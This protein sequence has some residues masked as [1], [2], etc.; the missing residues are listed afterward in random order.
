Y[1]A[2]YIYGYIDLEITII[3]DALNFP[4]GSCIFG[5]G[6]ILGSGIMMIHLFIRY[7]QLLSRPANLRPPRSLIEYGFW[8]GTFASL[9][10][11]FVGGFQLSNMPIT[12]WVGATVAFGSGCT[13]AYIETL[14]TSYATPQDR[15][16]ITVRGCSAVVQSITFVLTLIGTNAAY[17]TRGEIRTPQ[18]KHIGHEW[19]MLG[20]I[21]EWI[22]VT[23][24]A[25]FVASFARDFKHIKLLS[26]QVIKVI[27]ATCLKCRFES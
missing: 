20:A 26:P 14:C 6:L 16:L 2:A 4:P 7:H 19:L 25:L 13:F 12:H 8:S 1:I 21:S 9:G 22:L 18:N 15:F 24:T 5:Y 10:T 11:S 17:L 3:S 23:C 27:I